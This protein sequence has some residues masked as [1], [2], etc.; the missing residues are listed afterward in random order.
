[1]ANKVVTNTEEE[2]RTVIKNIEEALRNLKHA[3]ATRQK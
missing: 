3:F 2:A 1:M